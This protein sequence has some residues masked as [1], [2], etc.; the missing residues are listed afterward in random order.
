MSARGCSLVD[1]SLSCR[2]REPGRLLDARIHQ[3]HHR[4]HGLAHSRRASAGV[5]PMSRNRRSSSSARSRRSPHRASQSAIPRSG[6][7][8]ASD[9]A[10]RAQRYSASSARSRWQDAH[11]HHGPRWPAQERWL[12]APPL[13]EQDGDCRCPP[14]AQCPRCVSR[15]GPRTGIFRAAHRSCNRCRRARARR[16]GHRRG[17]RSLPPQPIA[18]RRQERTQIGS[19]GSM[20]RLISHGDARRSIFGRCVVTHCMAHSPSLTPEVREAPSRERPNM[21]PPRLRKEQSLDEQS[22]WESRA[23]AK[24]DQASIRR[25]NCS[26]KKGPGPVGARASGG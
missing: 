1:V 4:H 5:T 25:W 8:V 21:P 7:A 23:S 15:Q 9:C 19:S 20:N 2:G 3:G 17:S 24:P 26:R 16:R 6:R 11:D 14:R 18:R 13:R 22:S 12:A 10:V